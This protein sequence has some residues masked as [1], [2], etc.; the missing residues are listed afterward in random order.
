MWQC[1]TVSATSEGGQQFW[2]SL[3]GEEWVDRKS[4]DIINYETQYRQKQKEEEEEEEEE[5]KKNNNK[6]TTTLHKMVFAVG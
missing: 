1:V 5:K 2:G 6:K 3:F 4:S